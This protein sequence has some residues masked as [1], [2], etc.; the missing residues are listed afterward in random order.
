MIRAFNQL[1]T[2]N[3]KQGNRPRDAELMQI[4]A[5][6]NCTPSNWL[7]TLQIGWDQCH[8]SY[9]T[10]RSSVG[11]IVIISIYFLPCIMDE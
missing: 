9:K 11:P 10:L 4:Q 7:I 1:H 3:G 2:Y 5:L 6:R 8:F